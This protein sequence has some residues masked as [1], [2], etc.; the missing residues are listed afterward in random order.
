VHLI[1]RY[2]GD[3]LKLWPHHDRKDEEG[4]PVAEKIRKAM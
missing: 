3:G 1:P 2:Q 4:E